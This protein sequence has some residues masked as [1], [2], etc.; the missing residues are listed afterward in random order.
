[1]G[2]ALPP[3]SE[4]ESFMLEGVPEPRSTSRLCCQIKMQPELDGIVVSMP[5]EQV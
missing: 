3:M 5:L 4:T 1:M 2:P